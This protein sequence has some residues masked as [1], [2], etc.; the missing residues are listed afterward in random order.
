MTIY[1]PGDFVDCFFPFD[2]APDRPGPTPHVVYVQRRLT[3]A[4]QIHVLVFYTTT[5]PR[6]LPQPKRAGTIEVP[7][8]NARA[9]GMARA[10]TVDTRR[11]G[12]LP[13]RADTNGLSE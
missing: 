8:I 1:R 11:V 6:R 9:M 5:V 12:V 2:E 4:G 7:E 3:D 10:F 13:I